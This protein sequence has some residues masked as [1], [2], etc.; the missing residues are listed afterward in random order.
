[1]TRFGLGHLR[2]CRAIAHHLVERNRSVGPD[3]VGLADHRQLRFQSPGRFRAHAGRDQAAQRRIHARSSCTST[4]SRRSAMRSLDHPAHRR[5]LRPR[6]VPRRQ[7][8]AGAARRGARHADMLKE[9]ARALVLGLRDVMDEPGSLLDEWERKNVDPGAARPLR[10]D[11]GLWP[12]ADLRS[13]DRAAPACC[14]SPAKVTYTGY[15]RRSVPTAPPQ[16]NEH[17]LPAEPYI[18]VTTGGGGDGED[19]IDWVLRAY[20]NDPGIPLSALLVFG[21][22][23]QPRAAAAFQERA[24]RLDKVYAITFDARFEGLLAARARRGRDGWLQHVLRDSVVRQAGPDRAAHRAAPRAVPAGGA[25]RA[26]RSGAHAAGRRQ[27]RAR[28]DGRAAARAAELA[29]AGCGQRSKGCSAGSSRSPCWPRRG[30]RD[31]GRSSG[32]GGCRASPELPR[33]SICRRISTRPGP[34]KSRVRR[35][36][37]PARSRPRSAPRAD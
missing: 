7:G 8:A 1:M 31:T 15:L 27:A 32:R 9:R 37:P 24:A 6:P 36:R 21:P 34:A 25:G 14:R 17:E 23:M 28:P 33:A 19:L 10:R 30:S 5:H 35:A 22:F 11:L 29:G 13:A 16:S 18:L 3:P 12:A 20:E 2:R 4:S 26:A